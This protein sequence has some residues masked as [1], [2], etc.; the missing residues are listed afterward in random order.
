MLIAAIPAREGESPALRVAMLAIVKLA[1]QIRRIC[2]SA[3]LSS[4]LVRRSY[5]VCFGEDKGSD[6]FRSR[7]RG[8]PGWYIVW[9]PSHCLR[10]TQI[11]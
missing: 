9:H 10:N 4:L 2:S 11:L 7:F 3:L 8:V 5:N 6:P 1:A